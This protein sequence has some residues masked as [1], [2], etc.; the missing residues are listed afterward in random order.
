MLPT[1]V[2]VSKPIPGHNLRPVTDTPVGATAPSTHKSQAK[3]RARHNQ[4]G[5]PMSV[6]LAMRNA[7]SER[8][9]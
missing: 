2:S 5:W 8:H 1:G 3:T 7:Q 4:G 6:G 9:R